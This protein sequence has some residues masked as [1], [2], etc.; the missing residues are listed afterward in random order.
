MDIGFAI[1]YQHVLEVN[2]TPGTDKKTWAWVGPGIS[3]IEKD[4]S[5]TIDESTY[6]SDGGNTNAT[7]TG[8]TRKFNISGH[9]LHGDPFQDWVESIEEATGTARET[10]FR[11]TNPAGKVIEGRCTV[12]DIAAG[13]PNGDANSKSAFSCSLYRTDGATVT[14]EAKGTSLPESVSVTTENLTC[15]VGK[16][17]NVKTSVL[18]TSASDRC[19]FA[20]EDTSVATVDVDGTITGVKAGKTR[21][22]VKCAAKPSVS[23]V[24]EVEVTAAASGA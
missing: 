15:A 7:V 4:N 13:G 3:G 6:Y 12:T 8:V 20:I 11:L 19:L 5:E 18:P 14:S 24:K 9:R 22:A 21:L 2:I 17:V 16:T 23:V 1:N 10:D